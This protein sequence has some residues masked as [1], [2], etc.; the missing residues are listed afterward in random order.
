[1]RFVSPETARIHLK[2]GSDWIDV[3]KELTVGEDKKYR[4]SGFKRVAQG[5]SDTGSSPEIAI[6][7]SQMALA[8]VEAY[9]VDWSDKRAI[10]TDSKKRAAIEALAVD[11]F[12]EIDQAIQAH[13]EKSLQEKK[14]K[15]E[16]PKE[17]STSV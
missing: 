11:D 2:N 13:I 1:M 3:K 5:D 10:D 12:E 6:D 14:A 8:R 7:F 9:L 16:Q 15:K 4:T 17:M